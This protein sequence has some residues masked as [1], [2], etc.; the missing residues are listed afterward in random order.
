MRLSKSRNA[1]FYK[2]YFKCL[3]IGFFPFLEIRKRKDA[4]ENNLSVNF[5][6]ILIDFMS[7][8]L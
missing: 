5:L 2:V 8:L 6:F 7:T 4:K 1:D 3:I